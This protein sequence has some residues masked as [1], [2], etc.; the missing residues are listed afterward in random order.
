LQREEYIDSVG[1][2]ALFAT[3]RSSLCNARSLLF[4]HSPGEELGEDFSERSGLTAPF[5][6]CR[7]GFSAKRSCL[8]YDAKT[9]RGVPKCS[10]HTVDCN[11]ETV[12]SRTQPKLIASEIVILKQ[13]D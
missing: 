10:F 12:K 5:F 9:C 2:Q 4:H 8:F 11:S 1:F 3:A 6:G 7:D 13:L